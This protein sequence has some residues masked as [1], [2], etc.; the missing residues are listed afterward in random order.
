[1]TV[2][3]VAFVDYSTQQFLFPFSRFGPARPQW[4]Q[5]KIGNVALSGYLKNFVTVN[6]SINLDIKIK[7]LF[8]KICLNL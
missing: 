2:Y 3:L 4:L 1:M 6:V 7:T 8:R 5:C